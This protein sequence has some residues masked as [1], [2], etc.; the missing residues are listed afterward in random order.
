MTTP[1]TADEARAQLEAMRPR[2]MCVK[3]RAID[4]PEA[5]DES[6]A[7]PVVIH[8]GCPM[9]HPN[10][11]EMPVLCVA[12]VPAL[13]DDDLRRAMETIIALTK[14]LAGSATPPDDETIARHAAN[15]GEWV[16]SGPRSGVLVMTAERAAEAAQQHRESIAGEFPFSW[17]W[18]AIKRGGGVEVK[19]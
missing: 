10:K 5:T 7:G 1:F 12:A 9:D 6:A 4:P 14:A 3:C 19:P 17:R 11:W 2:M 18:L 15:G 8:A 16:V 13:A